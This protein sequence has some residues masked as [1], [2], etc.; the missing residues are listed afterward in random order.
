MVKRW[1]R[2]SRDL[3]DAGQKPLFDFIDP[4]DGQHGR[5]HIHRESFL[6]FR[7]REHRTRR[8]PPYRRSRY[9]R[10]TRCPSRAIKHGDMLLALSGGGVRLDGM[11]STLFR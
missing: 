1:L 11:I 10:Q 2:V 9:S 6:A 8:A 4:K 7:A 5:V 3:I